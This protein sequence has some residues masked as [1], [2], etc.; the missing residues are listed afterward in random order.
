M[1]IMMFAIIAMMAFSCKKDNK[2]TVFE[3]SFDMLVKKKDGTN[4]FT[5]ANS[6]DYKEQVRIAY[7]K[8]GVYQEAILGK[9]ALIYKN[10]DNEFALRV[11]VSNVID[12][13]I[14]RSLTKLEIDNESFII[15]S[16]LS[17]IGAGQGISEVSVNDVPVDL[18]SDYYSLN[19]SK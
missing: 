12:P 8:D 6:E 13:S 15:K 2:P 17:S 14:N 19:L 9:D 10:K 16:K 11:F 7:F 4:F 5:S 3:M 18:K 1:R